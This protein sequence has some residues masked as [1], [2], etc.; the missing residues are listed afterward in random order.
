MIEI[1]NLS[2]H[3][4]QFHAVQDISFTV[5]EGEILGF[6][7]PNGAGKSTT[8]RILCGCIGATSGTVTVN[9]M[10]VKTNPIEVKS[11]IGYLPET[12]PVYPSMVVRE[13]LEFC[14]TIKGVD[15]PKLATDKVIELV[16]LQD[17]QGRIIQHLSK[18]FRQR[19]GL[20][21]ALIHD[22]SVLVLDEPTS[23]LDPKQRREIRELLKTLA[24][25]K[26]TVILSTHVLGEIEAIFERVVI[27]ARGQVV[28]VDRLDAIY[29][30]A[31][32]MSIELENPSAD[33]KE[34][35]LAIPHVQEVQSTEDH[36]FTITSNEDV[37]AEI[38]KTVVDCGLLQ[39]IPAEGLE[40]VYIRLTGAT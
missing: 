39:L 24:Q 27:I 22:P 15:T 17:V 16:G 2:K 1:K 12:P 20:A 3:Y 30:E 36:F 37:R 25:G 18:G 13:Y 14:A 33:I 5:S 11:Q 26:R 21:Q 7:G 38:A 31:R 35:L 29:S 4:G 28:C 8:M 32:R 10:D 9:G 19:V 34:R 6:L 23:G 40:D